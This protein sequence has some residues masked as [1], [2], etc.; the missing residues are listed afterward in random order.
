[1]TNLAEQLRTLIQ[2]GVEAEIVQPAEY[3]HTMR[4]AQL[5]DATPP[6]CQRMFA[7]RQC[8]RDAVSLPIKGKRYCASCEQIIRRKS[9]N[10]H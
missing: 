4:L 10:Q 9:W 8:P 3:S 5:A 1:M 7:G 2:R 6:M